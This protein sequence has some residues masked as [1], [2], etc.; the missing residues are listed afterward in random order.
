MIRPRGGAVLESVIE[1]YLLDQCRKHRFL[2]MKFVSPAHDG[3]PDRIV[4]TPGCTVFVEVKGQGVEPTRLQL[5][6]H[7]KMRRFGAHVY[8]VDDRPGVDALMDDL[9]AHRR[10][11]QKA[12]SWPS[13]G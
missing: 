3:V 6:Q 4:I 8:V 5:R 10:S 13:D 9:A 1:N 11:D 2:C 7:A 12:T